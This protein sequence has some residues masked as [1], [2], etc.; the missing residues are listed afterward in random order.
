MLRSGGV[1]Q[2]LKK[3]IFAFYAFFRGKS[4]LLL[5]TTAGL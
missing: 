1:A 4:F 5:L 2:K 3:F